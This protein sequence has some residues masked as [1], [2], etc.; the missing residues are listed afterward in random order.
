MLMLEK[1]DD[2]NLGIVNHLRLRLYYCILVRC[3]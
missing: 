1:Y 3:L 2:V